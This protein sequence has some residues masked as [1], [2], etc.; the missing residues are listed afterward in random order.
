MPSRTITHTIGLVAAALVVP[1]TVAGQARP[2]S[3]AGSA[4][5]NAEMVRLASAGGPPHVSGAAS[6]ARLEPDGRMTVVRPGTNGFTCFLM[7]DP[8][9]PPVCGDTAATQFLSDAVAGK[10]R[11]T[12][13]KPGIAYMAAG[14]SHHERP[15]GQAVMQAAPGTKVVKEPPHWMLLWPVDA[16]T[17]GLPTHDTGGGAY[18]M[19]ADTPYAHLMI[20]QDP[21]KLAPRDG[22]GR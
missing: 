2:A 16:Q 13:T 14:G 17:S 19:F 7:P 11:P 10:P 5:A 15:D 3:N 21:R 1:M 4:S 8:G 12:N 18:I 22:P 6:I 20:H 9:N